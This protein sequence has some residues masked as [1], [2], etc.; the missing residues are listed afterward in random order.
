MIGLIRLFPCPVSWW[1]DDAEDFASITNCNELPSFFLH[2]HRYQ[3]FTLFPEDN[4][5]LKWMEM[6]TESFVFWQG[7]AFFFLFFCVITSCTCFHRLVACHSNSFAN[8]HFFCST[9]SLFIDAFFFNI[10][11][12]NYVVYCFSSVIVIEKSGSNK[13]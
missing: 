13:R 9:R 4:N 12:E 5:V 3:R 8:I 11:S 1:F 2:N 7:M 6:K 10:K